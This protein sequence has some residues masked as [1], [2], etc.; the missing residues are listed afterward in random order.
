M[1]ERIRM[2][3]NPLFLSVVYLI[4]FT[5]LIGYVEPVFAATKIKHSRVKK[6][7]VGERIPV[8][9]EVKDKAGVDIAR[10]YFRSAGS[11]DFNFVRMASAG[12]LY[13]GVLPAAA[14][15]TKEIVYLLLVK[16]A[17]NEVVKS[18]EFIIKVKKS[19]GQV[20]KP[21]DKVQVYSELATPPNTI[22][23][24]ADNIVVDGVESA[25]KFGVVA[26]LVDASAAGAGSDSTSLAST[27][28]DGAGAG[29]G[30][31]GASGGSGSDGASTAARSA[32]GDTRYLG[33]VGVGGGGAGGTA[34][35]LGG[36][37]LGGAVVAGGGG[38]GNPPAT[39]TV[40]G[41]N[42][43][44]VFNLSGTWDFSFSESCVGGG[45][46]W[47]ETCTFTQTGS[48]GSGPC[49]A[50]LVS[51]NVQ[52]C[53]GGSFTE[54]ITY[55]VNGNSV[56]Y[57]SSA[58]GSGAGTISTDGSTLNVSAVPDAGCTTPTALTLIKR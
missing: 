9:A 57:N 50:K 24:F 11:L 53:D 12:G 14:A 1:T 31:E 28:S 39:G 19:R 42:T 41:I 27:S 29:S 46:S 49:S 58:G 8:E 16:N 34:L 54:T 13:R 23:G 56:S 43:P 4:S 18:P 33:E 22:T 45:C 36:I 15:D 17:E 6:V 3:I 47:N 5:A 38:S 20:V 40:T 48:S 21:A 55:V 10:V 30:S 35:V 26:G 37:V 32:G 52:F 44:A 2:K 25:L 51:G 7:K